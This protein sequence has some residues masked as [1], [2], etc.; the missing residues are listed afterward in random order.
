MEMVT[1]AKGC[2]ARVPLS[3]CNTS[4]IVVMGRGLLQGLQILSA[5]DTALIAR[6]EGVSEPEVMKPSS[7]ICLKLFDFL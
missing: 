4:V 3:N 2:S 6:E 5:W 1:L 7:N